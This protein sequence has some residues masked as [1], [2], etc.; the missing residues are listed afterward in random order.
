MFRYIDHF[1]DDKDYNKL[2]IH[3]KVNDIGFAEKSVDTRMEKEILDGKAA[4]STKDFQKIIDANAGG[5]YGS[6]VLK[7]VQSDSAK[8][9]ESVLSGEDA[10][11]SWFKASICIEGN[12][13]RP[14][15]AAAVSPDGLCGKTFEFIPKE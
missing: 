6:E 14:W 8:V 3:F 4:V 7:G 12:E 9:W 15:T 5:P 2:V 10:G 11:K 13:E 1:F